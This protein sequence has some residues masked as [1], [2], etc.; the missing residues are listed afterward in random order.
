ME[1]EYIWE[2]ENVMTQKILFWPKRTDVTT[3]G[4]RERE[5]S[6]YGTG[7]ISLNIWI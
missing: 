7:T 4:E 3:L 1:H 6:F 2:E 5:M